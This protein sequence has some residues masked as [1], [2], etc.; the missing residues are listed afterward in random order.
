MNDDGVVLRSSWLVDALIFLPLPL[1]LGLVLFWGEDMRVWW[2][3]AALYTVATVLQHRKSRVVLTADGVEMWRNGRTT[4]PWSYVGGVLFVDLPYSCRS[5]AVL[6]PD[7]SARPLPAPRS[8]LGLGAR[9]VA[10]ARDL[11]E[12]HWLRHRAELMSAPPAG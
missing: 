3:L 2:P 11:I 12:Q 8:V 6:L 4:V 10:Q 9:D 7:R 5:V 1:A